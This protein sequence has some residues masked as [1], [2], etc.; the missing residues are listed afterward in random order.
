MGGGSWAFWSFLVP[1]FL[2]LFENADAQSR[3]A[4]DISAY[5]NQKPEQV[6]DSQLPRGCEAIGAAGAS[7]SPY[8]HRPTEMQAIEPP[9]TG[10]REARSM[11]RRDF[12]EQLGGAPQ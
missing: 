5:P 11:R 1:S 12:Q 10:P 6:G 7:A 2:A 9:E 8:P 3:P 4:R